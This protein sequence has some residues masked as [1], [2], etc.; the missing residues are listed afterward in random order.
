MHYKWSKGTGASLIEALHLPHLLE[1]LNNEQQTTEEEEEDEEEEEELFEEIQRATRSTKIRKKGKS[2]PSAK[3][4][5]APPVLSPEDITLR[6]LKDRFRSVR[7]Q[8]LGFIRTIWLKCAP[9]DKDDCR[10]VLSV[11]A[12]RQGVGFDWE[13]DYDVVCST[14]AEGI[15]KSCWKGKDIVTKDVPGVGLRH[16]HFPSVQGNKRWND[17]MRATKL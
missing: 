17:L 16:F 14:I 4:L 13:A 10:S 8:W 9:H 2:I 3:N 12:T 15:T 11:E 5:A 6:Q 1:A 7:S